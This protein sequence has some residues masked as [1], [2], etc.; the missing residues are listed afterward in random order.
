MTENQDHNHASTRMTVDAAVFSYDQN[1]RTLRLLLVERLFDPCKGSW[2]L[3]GGFLDATDLTLAAAASRELAEETSIS[4]PPN[5]FFS[6]GAFGDI[7]R[8]P[9]GRTITA[10]YVALADKLEASSARAASAART[11]SFCNLNELP[12]LA[13]DHSA[14]VQAALLTL[15]LRLGSRFQMDNLVPESLYRDLDST[16]ELATNLILG[17]S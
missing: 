14:I 12:D 7:D 4:L 9:R 15:V 8:D 13:F 3:P 17:W 5:R 1:E 11:L 16:V 10:A 6:C 2:A